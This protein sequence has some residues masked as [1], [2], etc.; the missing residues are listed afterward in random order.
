MT[1][2]L[3]LKLRSTTGV[4]FYRQIVDQITDQV[5]SGE[6]PAGARIPSVRE[7]AASLT[8]SVITTRRAYAELEAAGLVSRLQGQGTF[9]ADRPRVAAMRRLRT[10]ATEELRSALGRLIQLGLDGASLQ[11]LV[12]ELLEES[13]PDMA[14]DQAEKSGDEDGF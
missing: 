6:L 4:P 1:A 7:L 11:R 12:A 14:T 10:E 13:Q 5:V 3:G 9:V 2:D 8:V